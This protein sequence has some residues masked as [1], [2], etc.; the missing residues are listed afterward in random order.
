LK[1]LQNFDKCIAVA[2]SKSRKFTKKRGRR[3]NITRKVT[4]QE[5]DA[6]YGM[7]SLECIMVS[8]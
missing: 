6:G 3:E 4:D 7:D 5:G 1:I 2:D 8:Y